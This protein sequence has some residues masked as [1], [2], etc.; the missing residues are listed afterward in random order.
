[1]KKLTKSIAAILCLCAL[2]CSLS[3]CGSNLNGTYKYDYVADTPY[4]DTVLQIPTYMELTVDGDSYDMIMTV[5]I[6][7]GFTMCVGYSGKCTLDGNT[8][9]CMVP[10]KYYSYEATLENGTAVVDK[11]TKAETGKPEGGNFTETSYILDK[12]NGSFKPVEG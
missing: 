4:G 11:D 12:D 3:A 8:I 10:D 9:T 6:G 5:D 2:I 7:G 1:M